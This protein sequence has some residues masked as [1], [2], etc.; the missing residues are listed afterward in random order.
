MCASELQGLEDR[1]DE[2]VDVGEYFD[3]VMM[4]VI[5]CPA[6]SVLAIQPEQ[7]SSGLLSV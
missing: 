5:V 4:P 7:L 3:T 6:N 1:S 2:D